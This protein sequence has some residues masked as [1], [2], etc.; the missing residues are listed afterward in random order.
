MGTEEPNWDK[1]SVKM[2]SFEKALED[3]EALHDSDLRKIKKAH[4]EAGEESTRLDELQDRVEELE[5]NYKATR[6]SLSIMY[7]HFRE[8]AALSRRLHRQL[9][10]KGVLP[11]QEGEREGEDY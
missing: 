3:E 2:I 1:L 9:T 8:Q 7:N 6:S 11:E 4:K 5:D 10:E